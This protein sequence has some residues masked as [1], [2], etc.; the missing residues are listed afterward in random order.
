MLF[1]RFIHPDKNRFCVYF[2]NSFSVALR[3]IFFSYATTERETIPLM[4]FTRSLNMASKSWSG[5]AKLTADNVFVANDTIRDNAKQ[6]LW[7]LDAVNAGCPN[8]INKDVC[9]LLGMDVIGAPFI[10]KHRLDDVTPM[11]IRNVFQ[12]RHRWTGQ[13]FL[14]AI[15]FI[16]RDCHAFVGCA[17]PVGRVVRKSALPF[18]DERNQILNVRHYRLFLVLHTIHTL[19]GRKNRHHGTR[20]MYWHTARHPS[21]ALV[22]VLST[23]ASQ[24]QNGVRSCQP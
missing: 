11:G 9:D 15:R 20:K 8:P 23:H 1:N 18:E 14:L 13:T 2:N 21:A 7:F 16:S 12:V 24:C 3:P 22:C 10:P 19:A 4:N 6:C 5:S 17:A